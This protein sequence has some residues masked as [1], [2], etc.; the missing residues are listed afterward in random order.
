M[1]TIIYE[2]PRTG[3]RQV[4]ASCG[5]LVGSSYTPEKSLSKLQ[6]STSAMKFEEGGDYAF[7]GSSEYNSGH[8]KTSWEEE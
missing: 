8:F 1:E 6:V 5:M 3:R 7:D 2:R 4:N